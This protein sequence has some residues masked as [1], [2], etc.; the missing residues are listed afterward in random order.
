MSRSHPEIADFRDHRKR[1]FSLDLTLPRV[2]QLL[3]VTVELRMASARGDLSD[4]VLG[5][6]RDCL[7]CDIEPFVSED[8]TAAVL[9]NSPGSSPQFVG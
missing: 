5:K 4:Q 3:T 9:T 2:R 7:R 1:R 6:R 8:E